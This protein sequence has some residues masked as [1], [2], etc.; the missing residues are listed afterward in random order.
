MKSPKE[1]FTELQLGKFNDET[2]HVLELIAHFG[3]SYQI[4]DGECRAG[5]RLEYESPQR[6]FT[7]HFTGLATNPKIKVEEVSLFQYSK[8]NWAGGNLN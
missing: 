8:E 1:I 4:K 7:I 5:F 2:K 6:Y 3:K